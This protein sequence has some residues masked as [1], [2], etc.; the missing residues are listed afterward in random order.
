MSF[1][2]LIVYNFPTNFTFQVRSG[3]NPQYKKC[4]ISDT[5][6]FF[7]FVG[8]TISLILLVLLYLIFTYMIRTAFLSL[9][10]LNGPNPALSLFSIIP[11][12]VIP[13]IIVGFLVLPLQLYPFEL[14]NGNKEFLKKIKEVYILF[15]SWQS[16]TNFLIDF[17]VFSFFG[18]LGDFFLGN[19][20]WFI[21]VQLN[22]FVTFVLPPYFL[23]ILVSVFFT[24]IE[25][26]SS[27]NLLIAVLF[28]TFIC[29]LYFVSAVELGT[30]FIGNLYGH[31]YFNVVTQKRS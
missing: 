19:F 24:F 3:S 13:F 22:F 2:P 16:K 17:G 11:I 18:F 8:F 28:F 27:G 20:V 5:R 23:F 26:I 21:E 29:T 4:L 1:S 9:K 30:S 15:S 14:L 12:T 25:G 7:L 10:I 31:I 6:R